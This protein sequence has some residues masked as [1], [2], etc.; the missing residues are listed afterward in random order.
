[1]GVAGERWTP[2]SNG[3]I[4]RTAIALFGADRTMFGS[5]FPVDSL[6]ATFTEIVD[7]FKAILAPLPRAEQQAFFCDTARRVY[8]LASPSNG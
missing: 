8:R 2:E 7:G 3:W 5:N 4:V 6:C 1:M